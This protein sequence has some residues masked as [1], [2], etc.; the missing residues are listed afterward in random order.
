MNLKH[1]PVAL[2]ITSLYS[3]F[4]ER[5]IEKHWSCICELFVL[6]FKTVESSS[7][8]VEKTLKGC[9][10]TWSVCRALELWW[11]RAPKSKGTRAFVM[12]S[13]VSGETSVVIWPPNKHFQGQLMG[14]LPGSLFTTRWVWLFS[15]SLR[16]GKIGSL[17][18]SPTDP[19]SQLGVFKLLW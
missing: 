5:G 4:L 14:C 13:G 3:V 6:L 7:A 15:N 16:C 18:P 9:S 12:H 19:R 10:S 11:E 8:R 1:L 2:Q 17:W